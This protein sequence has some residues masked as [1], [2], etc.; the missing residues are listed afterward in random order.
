MYTLSISFLWMFFFVIFLF[1]YGLYD[2]MYY[3][4][5]L[6]LHRCCFELLPVSGNRIAMLTLVGVIYFTVITD[7]VS[8]NRNA[9]C[10]AR[11]SVRLFPLYHLD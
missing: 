9:I 7:R 11:P 4:S 3:R 6:K 1:M 2:Y 10:H 5:S 8:G